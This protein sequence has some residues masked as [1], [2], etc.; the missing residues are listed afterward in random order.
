MGHYVYDDQGVKAQRVTVV[1]KG[2]LKTFLLD[3]APLKSFPRSNGHGRAEPGFLPVSRQS[4]LQVESAKSRL[5]RTVDGS[6]ARRGVPP[7]QAVRAAV[8]QHRR[9][10]YHD[11]TRVG[12]RVQRAAEC[13]V[14]HL[15]RSPARA[16][17]RARRRSHR[18]AAGRVRKDHRAPTI[19]STSSTACA[20]PR[21]A[22]CRFRLRPLRCSSARSKCRRRCN[23]RKRGPFCRRRR[24]ARGNDEG[25]RSR[26]DGLRAMGARLVSGRFAVVC[27]FSTRLRRNPPRS[28]PCRTR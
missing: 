17:A 7:G 6:A 27:R 24:C 21:A 28:R 10:I 4:N 13:G 11:G 23:R 20:A 8:R 18:H 25:A 3:R 12:E 14:S 2:V 15:H 9:R 19:R 22:A 26:G 16:G 1:D 5:A